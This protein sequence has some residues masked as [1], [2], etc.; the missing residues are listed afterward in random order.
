MQKYF[1]KDKYLQTL[2]TDSWKRLMS[3]M[4]LKQKLTCFFLS[5]TSTFDLRKK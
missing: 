2:S 4:K 3:A 5:K 1:W